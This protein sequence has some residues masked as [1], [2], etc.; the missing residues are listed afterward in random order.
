MFKDTCNLFV[1]LDYQHIK[2]FRKEYLER[3]FIGV[4]LLLNINL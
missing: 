4:Y 2:S 3:Q 1:Q